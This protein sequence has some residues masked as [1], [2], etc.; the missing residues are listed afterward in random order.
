MLKS[1][2]RLYLAVHMW[3]STDC[4]ASCAAETSS[5]CT[6][7]GISTADPMVIT[8]AQPSIASGDSQSATADRNSTAQL[9]TEAQLR[10]AAQATRTLSARCAD[11]EARLALA[12]AQHSV[13]QDVLM[14]AKAAA[15][16]SQWVATAKRAAGGLN[17][18]RQSRR[19]SAAAT[20]P[21]EQAESTRASL[22]EA[23]AAA[24]S[25]LTALEASGISE[26]SDDA[27]LLAA[28]SELLRSELEGAHAAAA[29]LTEAMR[30]A[31]Q[32]P[33]R[34]GSPTKRLRRIRDLRGGAYSALDPE[35]SGDSDEE[36]FAVAPETGSS[37]MTPLR[38]HHVRTQSKGRSHQR[39]WLARVLHSELHA[40]PVAQS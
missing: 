2:A 34:S 38:A 20:V 14:A 31:Q 21:L 4:A 36:L 23:A 30:A 15:L 40:Q 39:G 1:D 5:A 16:L 26:G 27:C 37:I 32:Q 17:A 24:A 6:L 7:C 33:A 29:A 19:A 18:P 22:E 35:A 25:A 12:Q 3:A 13:Q 9:S 28:A 10:D 8:F 11:A